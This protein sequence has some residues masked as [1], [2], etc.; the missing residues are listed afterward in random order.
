MQSLEVPAVPGCEIEVGAPVMKSMCKIMNKEDN[1]HTEAL[2][3]TTFVE[4]SN[5]TLK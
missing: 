4:F 5:S 1:T 2:K 3:K